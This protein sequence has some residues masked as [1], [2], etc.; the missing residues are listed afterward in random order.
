MRFLLRG[1]VSVNVNSSG[2]R[3]I[4]A[5]VIGAAVMSTVTVITL[6]VNSGEESVSDGKE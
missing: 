2:D 1:I 5:G 3:V 4:A 6:P